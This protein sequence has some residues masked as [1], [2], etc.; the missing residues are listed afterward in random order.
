MV[1]SC[2][3]G[4]SPG[5]QRITIHRGYDFERRKGIAKCLA[6]TK[7][8]EEFPEFEEAEMSKPY[9]KNNSSK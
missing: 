2:Y 3:G 9:K 6:G 1:G 7:K 4:G 5:A 8:F